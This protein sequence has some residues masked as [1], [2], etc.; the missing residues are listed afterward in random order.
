M[1][2]YTRSVRLPVDRETAFAWHEREGAFSRL[3]PPW[4]RAEL[5]A[6]PTDGLHDGSRVVLRTGVGPF[7]LRWK[8]HHCDYARGQQFVD[9]M[10]RGPFRSWRHWHRFHDEPD[11]GARLEDFIRWSLP[12]PWVSEPL[13]RGWLVRKLDRMFEYRHAVT[14]ADL[15]AEPAVET[16]TVLVAGGTGLVG[17]SLVPALRTRGHAVRVLTRSPKGRVGHFRWNPSAGEVDPAALEG[18]DVIVNLNGETIAQRWTTAA[19]KRILESRIDSV[20]TIIAGLKSGGRR[21]RRFVGVSGSGYYGYQD[22]GSP[23]DEAADRGQGFLADVCREW[24]A[25]TARAGDVSDRVVI[26]RLGAVLTPAGGALAKL[27]PAFRAG[28][29]GPVGHG[30]QPMA[31]IGMEDVVGVLT[32]LV[33]GRFDLD[34]PVNLAIPGRWTNREFGR[35]LGRVLRR[36]AI[37]PLPGFLV[38]GIFGQMGVEVLLGGVEV[39]ADK[40]QAAGYRFRFGELEGLLRYHLGR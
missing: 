2:T 17:Q 26:P 32:G 35:T 15:S 14:V 10:D 21:V 22:R 5:V 38:R 11:G 16:L 27:L 8:L 37:F 33:E 7:G 20:D 23:Q 19:R 28:L 24:E 13:L 40:L 12:L 4:E 36:P 34:G 9:V 29:G 18:V 31:L 39:A 30:S 1:Q 6:G 3:Q 25:A